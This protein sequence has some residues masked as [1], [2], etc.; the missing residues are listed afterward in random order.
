MDHEQINKTLKILMLEDL[1]DD[2][3]LVKRAL[4]KGGFTFES[5]R[6]EDKARFEKALDDFKPDAILSDHAMPNFNSIEALQILQQKAPEIPFILV[7]GAVSDEFAAK[8]IKLG[9]DDYILKSNLSRLPASLKHA[10]HHHALEELRKKDEEALREQNK[11]LVKVNSEI[12]SF[13]YSVSHNLRSPLTSILGLVNIARHEEAEGQVNFKPYFDM[14]E[15][16]VKKLDETIKEILEYSR[17]ERTE[18]VSEAIDWA[19]I[20]NECLERIQYLAGFNQIEKKIKISSHVPFYSDA[21]R[22][23]IILS[24]LFSNAVCFLDDQK[25]YKYLQ[26]D[27]FVTLKMVRIEVKDNGIG[28][29]AANLPRIFNMFYRGTEKSAGAGLGLYIVKEMVTKLGGTISVTSNPGQDTT[30]SITLPNQAM[31]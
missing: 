4:R 3:S 29:S 20:I 31:A 21:Y 12:D 5:M 6:V 22:I 15:R 16:S 19:T 30:V 17:N 7:T 2:A 14:I 24:N 8:C 25:K 18:I 9:A 10:L 26:V 1:E 23:L 11:K 27:V 13:V 28:I